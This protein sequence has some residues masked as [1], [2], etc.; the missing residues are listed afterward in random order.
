RGA[1]A[2]KVAE[3]FVVLSCPTEVA[4]KDE[5]STLLCISSL[6]VCRREQLIPLWCRAVIDGAVLPSLVSC[7]WCRLAYDAMGLAARVR[8]RKVGVRDPYAHGRYC[9]C[10]WWC[11]WAIDVRHCTFYGVCKTSPRTK[12]MVLQFLPLVDSGF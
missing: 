3:S 10:W 4:G 12:L 11:S 6:A 5:G 7:Y 2:E 8:G 9:L 1:E